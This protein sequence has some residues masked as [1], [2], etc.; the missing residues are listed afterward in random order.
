MNFLEPFLNDCRLRG[1]D[2]KT[3]STYKTFLVPF[4]EFAKNHDPQIELFQH[5]STYRRERTRATALTHIKAYVH[6]CATLGLCEDWT[7]SLHFRFAPAPVYPTLSREEFRRI[8]AA[9][10]TTMRG[11]RD[12]ALYAALFFTGA[13]RDAIRL[14]RREDVNLRDRLLHVKTKG[15]KEQFLILP[16][17]AAI[18]LNGWLAL[19]AR[20]QTPWIFPS[21][22][23]PGRPLDSSAVTHALPRYAHAAGLAKRVYV[24]G[25]RHSY[26][27]ILGENEVPLEVIQSALGHADINIT[28]AYVHKLIDVT[29]VRQAMDRVF[30]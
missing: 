8:L 17:E 23:D 15:R 16:T 7:A 1:L 30:S 29:R 25:L 19:S 13:R 12:K 18:I 6:R 11:R 14:L 28:R 20:L 4:I 22:R 9:I 5:L 2:P 24:H 10:P 26:A 3:I 21:L 27:T